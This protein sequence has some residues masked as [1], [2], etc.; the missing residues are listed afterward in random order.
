MVAAAGGVDRLDDRGRNGKPPVDLGEERL[1][2]PE[3]VQLARPLQDAQHAPLVER[4]DPGLPARPDESVRPDPERCQDIAG[5][6]C[7][8]ACG[9]GRRAQCTTRSAS[10]MS[11]EKA[12]MATENSS[13]FSVC[14]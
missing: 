2:P 14:I 11:S 6:P 4:I 9:C 1:L 12:G 5:R 3:R 7:G 10:G 13:P 8:S